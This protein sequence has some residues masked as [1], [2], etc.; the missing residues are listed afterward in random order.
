LKNASPAS[1]L[2]TRAYPLPPLFSGSKFSAAK[3]M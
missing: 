1:P 2:P 3:S